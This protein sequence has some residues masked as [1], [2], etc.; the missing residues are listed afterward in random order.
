MT[1]NGIM[2]IISHYFTKFSSVEATYSNVVEVRPMP[3]TTKM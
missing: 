1:L 3:S 2:A